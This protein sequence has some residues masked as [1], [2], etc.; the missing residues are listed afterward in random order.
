[1]SGSVGIQAGRICPGCGREESIPIVWGMPSGDLFELAEQGQVALGGCLLDPGGNPEW[2]CRAC[3]LDW[4]RQ[5]DPTADEQ[6]LA[7]ALRVS[8]PTV[9]RALGA[10]WRREDAGPDSGLEWFTS[11]QP[12]QLSIGVH[13]GGFVLARPMVDWGP[14]QDVYPPGE[15]RL[16]R[17]D[18]QWFPSEVTRVA[19]D[20]ASRRRRSFRWCRTCRRPA[21]PEAFHGAEMTCTACLESYERFHE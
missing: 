18:L 8:W 6:A 15:H 7:D 14:R 2:S 4:G 1:M 12:A 11:G 13:G 3:G 19:E 9:L 17:E 16:S 10:G 20:I 5:G 21:A